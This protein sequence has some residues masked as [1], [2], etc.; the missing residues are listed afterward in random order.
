MSEEEFETLIEANGLDAELSGSGSD[1]SDD[2]GAEESS[3]ARPDGRVALT[4]ADGA[5]FLV[6]RAALVPSAAAVAEEDEEED[7]SIARKY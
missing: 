4:D 7:T 2:E 6:W 3:A 5:T 1:D